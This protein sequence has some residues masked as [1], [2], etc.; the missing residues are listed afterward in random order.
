MKDC[1]S[2]SVKLAQKDNKEGNDNNLK[3]NV[4]L[5]IFFTLILCCL[6]T[7]F[8]RTIRRDPKGNHPSRENLGNPFQRFLTTP[9]E[10]TCQVVAS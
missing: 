6:A 9:K 8:V 4:I 1:V 5:L 7:D 3:N 2:C 10:H